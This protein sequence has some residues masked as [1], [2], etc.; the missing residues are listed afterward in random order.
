MR[1]AAGKIVSLLGITRDISARKHAEERL[2][3]L[4]HFDALTGL[5]N[6]ILFTNRINY[7]LSLAQR[8]RTQLA[9]MF[10]DL[11]HFKN[12]N[13]SLGHRIGVN[14]NCQPH[15]IGHSRAGHYFADGRG[16]VHSGIA[17]D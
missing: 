10:L 12:I 15:E 4:A 16:R 1:D 14:R 11:D 2:V 17:G 3:H 6:R 8:S 9:V 13:D 5:P 7:A